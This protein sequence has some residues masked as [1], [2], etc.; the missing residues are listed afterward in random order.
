MSHTRNSSALLTR[1]A[2]LLVLFA[3]LAAC[4]RSPYADVPVQDNPT[5]AT[6]EQ[7]EL[8]GIPSGTLVLL[9]L[10]P[11]SFQDPTV[12]RHRAGGFTY[13]PYNL[14]VK[15]TDFI[16]L[17]EV[18]EYSRFLQRKVDAVGRAAPCPKGTMERGLP[19]EPDQGDVLYLIAIDYAGDWGVLV[20]ATDD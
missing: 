15:C 19:E 8:Y 13:M 6:G 11:T 5:L 17:Q 12:P 4:S 1:A 3:L 2:S 14:Y 10:L 20:V 9:E 7:Q 18:R 16:Q